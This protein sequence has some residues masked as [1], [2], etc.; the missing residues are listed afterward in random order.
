MVLNIGIIKKQHGHKL[1]RHHENVK[2]DE[3]KYKK[4]KDK[5]AELCFKIGMVPIDEDGWRV[6]L[7][8]SKGE[9]SMH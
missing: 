4:I 6:I 8:M 7:V 9:Q 3:W 5:N 2:M 1:N